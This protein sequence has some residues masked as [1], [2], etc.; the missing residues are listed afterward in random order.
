MTLIINDQQLIEKKLIILASWLAKAWD[1]FGGLSY[2][3]IEANS[4]VL[5]HPPRVAYFPTLTLKQCEYVAKLADLP[6][7]QMRVAMAIL[8][9]VNG[10]QGSLEEQGYRKCSSCGQLKEVKTEFHSGQKYCK[11]CKKI[12]NSRRV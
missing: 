6:L 12:I 8:R 4:G 3:D 9:G 10:N 1:D 11:A 5:T 7:D 2:L